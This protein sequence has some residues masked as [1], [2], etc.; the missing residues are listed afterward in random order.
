M[1]L[2]PERAT[3][4]GSR[5]CRLAGLVR[6]VRGAPWCPDGHGLSQLKTVSSNK[7]KARV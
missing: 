6:G 3:A 2:S 7:E 1:E 5:R 4:I